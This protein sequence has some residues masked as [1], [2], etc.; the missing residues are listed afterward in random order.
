MVY[1]LLDTSNACWKRAER[2]PWIWCNRG[3]AKEE[4]NDAR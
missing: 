1:G 4:E 3:Y 2:M